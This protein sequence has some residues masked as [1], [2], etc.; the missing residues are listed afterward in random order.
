LVFIALQEYTFQ[1]SVS[2]NLR[3]CYRVDLYYFRRITHNKVVWISWGGTQPIDLPN[4]AYKWMHYRHFDISKT[5]N[6]H[7][8]VPT[9]FYNKN[10]LFEVLQCSNVGY[11]CCDPHLT[12]HLDKGTNSIPSPTYHF[13]QISGISLFPRTLTMP[14]HPRGQVIR[15]FGIIVAILEINNWLTGWK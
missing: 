6:Q 4:K 10:S 15:E 8:R 11:H 2:S 3:L 7:R 12:Q 9:K 13:L 5:N 1:E 14:C